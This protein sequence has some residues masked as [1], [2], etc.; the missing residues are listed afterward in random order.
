MPTVKVKSWS[1]NNRHAL[2]S[3][4][5]AAVPVP[6]GPGTVSCEGTPC[7][8][9]VWWQGAQPLLSLC[10]LLGCRPGGLHGPVRAWRGGPRVPGTP[11]GA[12]GGFL[13]PGRCEAFR[14][15]VAA[16][17]NDPRFGR[18]GGAWTALSCSWAGASRSAGPPLGQRREFRLRGAS[19][20]ARGV[21]PDPQGLW[22]CS[23][24]LG[25]VG[26]SLKALFTGH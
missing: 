22:G 21:S 5:P 26:W 3:D 1:Q 11:V 25:G 15:E 6:T 4:R 9:T 13:P 16:A 19:S 7:V 12:P 18:P 17:T 8:H 20:I 2:C 24:C 14:M 23:S 10:L